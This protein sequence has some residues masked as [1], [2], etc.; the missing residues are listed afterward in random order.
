[1]RITLILIA[2]FCIDGCATKSTLTPITYQFV[3]NPNA[4]QIELTY[5]NST[6]KTYCLTPSQWP[7]H[8]GKIDQGSDYVFLVVDGKK[9]PVEDFNAGYCPGGCPSYV[10]PGEKL[11][12]FITYK[13]FNLPEELFDKPKQLEFVPKAYQCSAPRSTRGHESSH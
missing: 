12:T 13:D 8:A 1:M 2:I 10:K 4:H 5:L 11:S 3:D 7:N 6:K 9:Y